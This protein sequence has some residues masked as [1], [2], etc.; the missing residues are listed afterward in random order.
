M[1]KITRKQAIHE[2]RKY[3]YTGKSCLHGHLS[4]RL[5][6]T[7]R[8]TACHHAEDI[9]RYH[10]DRVSEQRRSRVYQRRDLP[11]PTRPCPDKC[12]L[13]GGLPGKRALHLDH[14]HKTGLFRGWLCQACNLSLGKFGDEIKG[15]ERAIA[16]LKGE[17]YVTK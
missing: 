13:C 3:Y 7:R 8:C 4:K 9:R 15:L 14:D 6:S 5:V 16:Y 17:T 1:N 2:H 10:R 12:E 11:V